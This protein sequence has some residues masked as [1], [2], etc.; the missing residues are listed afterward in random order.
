LDY[1]VAVVLGI[2]QGLTE[3]LP[4]SSSAHLILGRAFFGW[5]GDGLGLAFDVACHLGTLAAVLWYFRADLAPLARATPAALAGGQHPQARLVRLVVAGTVPIAVFGLLASDWLETLRLPW[6]CAVTLVLGAVGMMVA[7]RARSTPRGG[8]DIGLLDALAI[9]CGQALALFPGMSRSGTTITVALL[10]G[11][12]R[13]AAARF[14]FLMSIP[15]VVAAAARESLELPGL[16][17][18]GDAA[19]LFLVGALVSGVVG[20][21][22]ISRL[23]Q[24]LADHSLD[25]FA[26][27]RFALAG[28]VVAWL[29]A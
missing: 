28:T 2:V 13:Q 18:T 1:L 22:A 12:R 15:A 20:Y 24:Y 27:Y 4:V 7:E 21:I 23:M 9:G 11:I 16:R 17:L 10:L 19:G 29:L 14:T 8:G 5:E 26:Y 6:V 25:V 3:F